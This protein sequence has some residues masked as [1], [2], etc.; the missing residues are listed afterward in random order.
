MLM[1]STVFFILINIVV[2]PFYLLILV[3]PR[4]TGTGKALKSGWPLALPAFVHVAFIVTIIAFSHPDI[5]GIWRELYIDHG[6]FS[7]TTVEFLSQLY[8][9]YPEFAI[10]HGWVH[11]VVGDMFMTRWAYLDALS[12]HLPSWMISFVALLIAFTGPLGIICYFVIRPFFTQMNVSEPTI[13]S[14][15]KGISQ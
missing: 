6:M 7:S 8:G 5:I 2:S 12:R 1:L 9:M 13:E 11:I 3:A 10:L 4:G 15:D 14:L